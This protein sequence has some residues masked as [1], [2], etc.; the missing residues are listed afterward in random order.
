[1]LFA[2]IFKL[3]E[4]KMLLFGKEISSKYSQCRI[5]HK[6]SPPPPS[7]NINIVIHR[8]NGV[9]DTGNDM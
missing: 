4:S 5:Y 8:K 1:M 9:T 6:M 7:K 2:N 3:K